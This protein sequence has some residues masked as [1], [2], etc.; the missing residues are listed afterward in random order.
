MFDTVLVANRGEIAVRVIRTLRQL[1]VTS[2]AV[3]SDADAGARH[4]READRAVRIG[5]AAAAESYLSATRLLKAAAR[6]G[7]QAVHPGYGFLAENAAF[8]RACSE[9]GLVFVGPPAEAVELM[10]DKIRAKETVRQAGVPV[11]PGSSGS[12]LSDAQ[13]ADAAREIGM[14]VL[15]KPSA[16]GG[17]KGMRLVRDESALPEEIAAARR[18]ALGSFGDDT[19]LVE[20][21]IDRPRHIEIQVLADAHGNVVH[22][23]ERECS[24]QRRHQKII[25]EAP[26]PLLDEATREA[27]GRAAVDAAR[28]CGYRGAGTV[29]FIVPGEAPA[30]SGEGTPRPYYFMEMNTRLQVEHPVTE[31]ITGLDL[32]EWQLRVAAGERLPFTQ[33]DISLDGHAVEARICAETARLSGQEGRVDFLP[34]AGTVLKLREPGG[35]QDGAPADR[36]VRT[37]SGLL[38]GSE[39]GTTYDPML[40]KV[41]AHG[42]DRPTALRRLRGAL[43]GTVVL[44]VE[45]NTGFLRRLLAHDDVAAGDLDTGLVDRDAASLVPREVPDEVYAAAALLRQSALEPAEPAAAAGATDAG[46]TDPFSLPSGWRLGGEPAWTVHHVRV[47]GHEPVALRVRG[48][49]PL[50]RRGDALEAQVRVGSSEQRTARLTADAATD[51]LLLDWDGLTVS[52][53]H[54][55]AGSGHWLGL[56]GDS[57]HIQDHDPVAAALRGGAGAH[58]ADALTAPM[59]GTVT[60]V[61]AAAGDEVT[62]GQS[63]LV[64]EAMKMEHV[65]TAPHDGTVTELDVTAGS[66]VA[67][68]Q[69][70][71]VVEPRESGTAESGTSGESGTRE[72]EAEA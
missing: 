32:V 48:R 41:I 44:G 67:M 33:A 28:S 58:G 15:L 72:K 25:E 54:A 21:W 31:M 30:A 66:T 51:R 38:T 53:D 10:G 1:G 59:P 19:L 23:G 68:D 46:W 27:M 56:D 8:A 50:P 17:G 4:V 5:P 63:L 12:G 22:L 18:E 37:D 45:T 71:A 29:E 61:K 26:S 35:G 39:V 20:R 2:V 14:P 60:V 42:P 65:I 52:L 7:A 62:A 55:P 49:S 43:A 36:S 16:G 3:H 13:L 24:L 11:V 47:P 57:W 69:V 64:V 6:G 9:A 34:S 70:L 40:A